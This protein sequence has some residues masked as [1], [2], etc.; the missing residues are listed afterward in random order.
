MYLQAGI[1]ST[2]FSKME[3][4]YHSP[5]VPLSP[6]TTTPWPYFL[7]GL[8]NSGDVHDDADAVSYFTKAI[9][10]AEKYPGRMWV[11]SVEFERCGLRDWQEK[12][13]KKLE[14]I[15]LASGAQAAPVITQQLLYK[16]VKMS[17]KGLGETGELYN[18]WASWFDKDDILIHLQAVQSAGVLS[19]TKVL[20]RL[21]DIVD[22][23]SSS[24]KIQLGLVKNICAWFF[25]FL[26]IAMA[27]ILLGLGPKYFSWA[28]HL[29]SERLPDV[30]A[31]KAKLFLALLVF[32]SIA[33]LGQL[34]FIWCFFFIIW[35]FCDSK[36]KPLAMIALVLFLLFPLSVKLGD[37]FDQV[38]SPGGSVMLYK[39]ALDEG[40]YHQLDSCIRARTIS[41]NADYLIHTASAL[42]SLKKGDPSAA[43]P[44]LQ[45]AQRLFRN[46]PAVLVATG[47]T[48]F[49]GGDLA[50]AR[51]AYQECISLYPS[52]EPAFFNLGQYYFN[53]META[54][55]MEYI[56]QAT[57][58]N[59]GY[60][61]AFIKKNDEC[62]SKDWPP[63][64][65][66]MAPD[67]SPMYFWSNIFPEYCGT[68]NT[69]S[70]RFGGMFFGFSLPLYGLLSLGLLAI[71]LMMDSL[72]WSKAVV[73]KVTAC[74]LCQ[75]IVCRK[76]KRGVI[77]KTCFNAT[78]QIRNEQIRQRI[79]SK[80]QSRTVRF[81][82]FTAIFLNMF[83]PGSGLVYR[84]APL[85]QSL[86][87]VATTSIIYATY[88]ALFRATF[89]FPTWTV[90]GLIAQAYLVLAV[91]NIFFFGQGLVKGFR[92]LTKR[93][94]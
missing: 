13:I 23:I 5:A 68:W 41:N 24:W 2:E 70:Q 94:E 56:T 15:F 16:A 6:D 22:D 12:C 59:P 28:L 9:A 42:Y 44:H 58:L 83:F 52:Y 18:S 35:R 25:T 3:P 11:L 50:G 86:S 84:G 79:M 1:R 57:K 32:A 49:Y 47:N 77:C 37:M 8:S 36:D 61:N 40:Y 19:L 7:K 69:A 20:P 48:L 65:Q 55:G 71:L 38:L 4:G 93:G 21:Q 82:T 66:L 46:N 91:Y 26:F 29:P 51:G 72:V 64:R 30:F 75:S 60:V 45:I 62:F 34:A 88:I 92:E 14:Q 90:Q 78:Q 74:K 85:Y 10:S 76:C 73:K 43:A 63:L 31:P 33:F 89:N 53:T 27:G 54:K 87:L 67:F 39:K 17:G 80:I 81:R